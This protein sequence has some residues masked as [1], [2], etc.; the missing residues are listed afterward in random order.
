MNLNKVQQGAVQIAAAGHILFITGGIA[1]GKTKTV[2]CIVEH[3][4]QIGRNIT[5][6]AS[7]GLASLQIKGI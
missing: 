1:T 6:A 3:M 4:Q 2:S 7:T 5:V